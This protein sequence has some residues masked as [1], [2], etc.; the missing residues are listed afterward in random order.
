MCRVQ[1]RQ[2]SLSS[3]CNLSLLKLKSCAD[4][5]SHTVCDNLIIFG[6]DEEEDK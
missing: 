2:L 4:H 6:R 5:N 3:L 1:E